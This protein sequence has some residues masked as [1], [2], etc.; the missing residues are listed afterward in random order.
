MLLIVIFIW[1]S[2]GF[3]TVVFSAAIKGVP[4]TLIEAAR[5]D[6][7]TKRQAFYK[8]TLPYIRATIVTVATTT[9][10]GGLKAFDIVAATTGGNFG[11]STQHVIAVL[12]KSDDGRYLVAD[13]LY[14]VAIA[15]ADGAALGGGGPVLVVQLGVGA[16]IFVIVLLVV[17]LF[18]TR[19]SDAI[20]DSR[21]GLIDRIGGFAFG[22]VRGFVIVLVLFMGY[23]KF[24]PEKDQHFIVTKAKS[25]PL[26]LSAGH[27]LEAPLEYLYNRY[28][29]KNAADQRAG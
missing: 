19:I 23:H 3:A 1:A 20:L 5:V 27:A 12:R 16:L 26:L 24:F 21:I 7:A 11:T 17:H 29:N 28:L 14:A 13:P 9:I 25:R 10:I 8:V 15:D 22:V 18:T 4:E 2:T 6:G